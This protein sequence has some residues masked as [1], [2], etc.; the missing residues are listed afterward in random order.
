MSEDPVAEAPLLEVRDLS[1]RREGRAVLEGVS[2]DVPPGELHV[3]IGPNGAGK[4]TLL[5]ALLGEVAFTGSVRCHFRG[6]RRIGLVP[7]SFPVDPTL[8]VTVMEMLA[9]SRQALPVC[10]GVRKATRA[11]IEALLEQV[12]LGGFGPRRLGELS[13]G[14][15]R[16][17]LLAQAI[18]PA[19]ELLLL[20]EPASGLDQGSIAR[21]EA[22]TR[23][24]CDEAKT[25][26]VMVS[27]EI[28]QVR[29][30]ADRVL[31]IERG[32]KQAGTPAEVLG[33]GPVF[34]FHGSG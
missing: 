18:D 3:V 9:L 13:G 1:L 11:R 2:F 5:A 19:P 31:W 30:V 23:K 10:L 15:L 14:E 28:G 4:S 16:R 25:A 34:P 22:M 8:P 29:R 17:V 12:G 32:L 33:E 21:L 24:L 7:Q 6:S 27:H 20:D 26:I